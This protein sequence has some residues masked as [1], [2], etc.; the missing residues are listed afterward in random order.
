MTDKQIMIDGVDVSG[1][2]WF[3]KNDPC[4]NTC[5]YFCTPC[6]WVQ[7]QNC[8]YKYA[9]RKEQENKDLREDIKDIANLLDLDTGEEYNF[10]NIE[11]EIKQLKAKEQ[12]CE[13]LRSKN[14]YSP[15]VLKQCPHYKNDN[16]CTYLGYETKCEGDCNYTAFQDFIAEIDDLKNVNSNLQEQLE[17]YKMEAEEGKEI[18]AELKAENDNL[19]SLIWWIHVGAEGA[20]KATTEYYENRN[21]PY[22]E[23]YWKRIR[24]LQPPIYESKYKLALTEIKEIAENGCYDDCGMPLDELS[25][26][27]QKISECEGNDG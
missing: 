8:M 3:Y 26:I 17:A 11:L 9:K 25:I 2:E 1:C 24:A 21:T 14:N 5:K 20:D 12:E 18:N 7:I 27:L 16:V 10:G 6:E 4:K 13:E 15:E 19:K 22:E 23:N